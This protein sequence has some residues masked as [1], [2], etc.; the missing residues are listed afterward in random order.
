MGEYGGEGRE[1]FIKLPEAMSYT[2]ETGRAVASG[3]KESGKA[4]LSEL[5]ESLEA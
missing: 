5:M 2:A 4:A 3:E 1:Q